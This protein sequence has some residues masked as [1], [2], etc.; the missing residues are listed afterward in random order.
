MRVFL[1]GGTG[2][3]GSHVA[4]R[5]RARGDEVV[6][7]HRQGSDAGFLRELRCTLVSGDVRDAPETLALGMRG[8]RAVV[9]GAALVYAEESW[10]RVHA[11]NVEG[12]KNVLRAAAL[13]AAVRAPPFFGR[14][15]R[16]GAGSDR[17]GYADRFSAFSR[18]SLR[19]FEA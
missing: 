5:L 6:A 14:G 19:A 3:I 18:R 9:H 1:T 17:R 15:L 12:T 11:V 10:P 13:A 8:C 2:L 7:L 16:G 4:E